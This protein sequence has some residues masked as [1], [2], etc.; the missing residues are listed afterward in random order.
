MAGRVVWL[1]EER[2]FAELINLG[3]YYSMVR[4]TRFGHDLEV[5]VPNDEFIYYGDDSDED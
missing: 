2:T 5:L 4:Y 1:T 3:A